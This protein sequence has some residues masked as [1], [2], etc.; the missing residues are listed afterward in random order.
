V[1]IKDPDDFARLLAQMRL[2][3]EAVP[4]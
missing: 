1:T 3:P 2:A 4:R